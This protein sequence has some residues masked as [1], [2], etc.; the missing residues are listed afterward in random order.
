[1]I[2]D[3]TRPPSSPTYHTAFAF[4]HRPPKYASTS[5]PFLPPYDPLDDLSRS[6]GSNM[7]QYLFLVVIWTLRRCCLG[8]WVQG[9]SP[10]IVCTTVADTCEG[11][12]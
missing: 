6:H 1:M 8:E 4:L 10:P 11:R 2:A 5:T 12:L 3:F 7:P 9:D